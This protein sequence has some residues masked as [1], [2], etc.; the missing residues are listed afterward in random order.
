MNFLHI[1]TN[2]LIKINQSGG[3][4]NASFI[5]SGINIHKVFESIVYTSPLDVSKYK[6][7]CS[8]FIIFEESFNVSNYLEVFVL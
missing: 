3:F 1:N 4:N 8:V 6:F 2:T 7:I 5:L